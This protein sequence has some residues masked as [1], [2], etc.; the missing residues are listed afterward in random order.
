[1]SPLNL[2]MS[3]FSPERPPES[4]EDPGDPPTRRHTT[5]EELAMLTAAILRFYSESE[6]SAERAAI[7]K[8]TATPLPV[9]DGRWTTRHVRLWFSNNKHRFCIGPCP[10]DSPPKFDRPVWL[11]DLRGLHF[12]IGAA[13]HPPSHR[14]GRRRAAHAAS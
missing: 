4:E 7:H 5:R 11:L 1:M 14:P 9:M 12:V 13:S 3:I 2:A 6:R 8:E 10:G